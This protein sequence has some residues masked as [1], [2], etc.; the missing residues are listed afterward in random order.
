MARRAEGLSP[1]QVIRLV[2]LQ[3]DIEAHDLAK[4]NAQIARE[5]RA[6]RRVMLRD[7]VRTFALPALITIMILL[8]LAFA[9]LFL[10]QPRTPSSPYAD[11]VGAP[12]VERISSLEDPIDVRAE[13]RRIA[14][15]ERVDAR[16]FAAVIATESEWRVDARGAA[17]EY[18]LVQLMPAT[19]I[20]LGVDRHDVRQ[21]LRGGAMKLRRHYDQEGN[22][23]LALVRYNGRGPK[24]RA[25][26]QRVL[27]RWESE[28]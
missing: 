9:V 27:R 6:R 18:C 12:P 13:A 14:I 7:R 3:T 4:R 19:A 5:L 10:I 16:L 20:E 2:S 28:Q 17:G 24:A 1:A 23:T 11:P 26:A 8:A 22:W 15:E 25:Y 21:C